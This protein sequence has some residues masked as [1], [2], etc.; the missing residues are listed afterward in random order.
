M[1]PLTQLLNMYLNLRAIYKAVYFIPLTPITIP[2]CIT[3]INLKSAAFC[4]FRCQQG[5]G[6]IPVTMLTH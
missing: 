6:I 4:V 2:V 5:A 3:M 1:N